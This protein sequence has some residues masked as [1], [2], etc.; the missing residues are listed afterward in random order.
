MRLRVACEHPGCERWADLSWDDSGFV[1]GA[2]ADE[3]EAATIY[4]DK[5]FALPEGW[6]VA[7]FGPTRLRCPEHPA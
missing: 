4:F 7:D 1:S 2:P 6:T 3:D 5:S